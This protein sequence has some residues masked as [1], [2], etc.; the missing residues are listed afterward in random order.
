[1]NDHPQSAR[2][3]P[4]AIPA[5]ALL[6]LCPL[7][8]KSTTLLSGACMGATAAVVLLG[9]AASL[10]ACRRLVPASAPLIFL[11]LLTAA[12]VSVADLALQAWLF[13]LRQTLG[14]YV[15]LIAANCL[16]LSVLEERVLREGGAALRHACLTGAWIIL[17]ATVV[18]GIR[19]LAAGGTLLA[20]AALIGLAP[21]QTGGGTFLAL[22]HAPAGALLA[23]GVLAAGLQSLRHHRAAA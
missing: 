10:V 15:P 2:M 20:D 22:M 3:L 5:V 8:A 16:L 19:E 23:L 12:W 21:P 7:L 9:S 6:G 11:L 17:G 14:A 4:S 13:S 18:G 1:M